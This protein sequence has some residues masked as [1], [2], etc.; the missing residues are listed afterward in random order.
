MN[1]LRQISIISMAIL[2]NSWT[3]MKQKQPMVI[4]VNYK[5]NY[6]TTTT[7]ANKSIGFD[8]GVIQS[9]WGS[10]GYFRESS[11]GEISI[12]SNFQIT[13]YHPVFEILNQYFFIWAPFWYRSNFYIAAWGLTWVETN[14]PWHVGLRV[15]Q[16]TFKRVSRLSHR[17]F[18]GVQESFKDVSRKCQQCFKRVSRLFQGSFKGVS[19]K[20]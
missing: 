2:G 10:Y 17:S 4:F 13:Q 14:T 5:D 1:I 7:T 3:T 19:K 11:R 18:K 12:S 9:Y 8:L 15:L 16:E 6:D 20:S